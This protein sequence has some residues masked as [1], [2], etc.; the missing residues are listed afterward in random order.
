M[1]VTFLLFTGAITTVLVAFCVRLQ[2]S[3]SRFQVGKI[4]KLFGDLPSVSVCIPARNETHA[5]TQCLERVLASDYEKLEVVVYDDSSADDTSILIRSFA[6]V[7]VR[8][9]PGT[10]LPEG[11][12]GKNHAL[13]VL[14][15]EASGTYVIFLDVDTFIQPTTI[16]Q[17]VAY[18]VSERRKM[19]SVIPERNDT[20]RVSVLLGTLRY[21]WQLVLSNS[22][23]LA[24]SS[25]VWLIE[26]DTLLGVI[27]G[28]TPFKSE[29]QP[30]AR[31]A[32]LLGSS[33]YHC[34][35]SS[36]QLGV[37]YEKRW[38]SQI[39]TSRRLLYPMAGGTV[40]RG[41]AA[42]AV[43]L[44]LNVPLF[45]IL[46]ATIFGWTVVQIMALW[47]LFSF[48]ALYSVYTSHVWR[49]NWWIGGL[50]WPVVILQE[51]ILYLSSVWGYARHTITWKGRS[52]TA[53]VVNDDHLVINT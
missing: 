10:K 45:T 20:W 22:R 29:V 46:S 9:V 14:A 35:L 28:F 50:L 13:E 43:L 30:E 42:F 8:F 34:L 48:M 36:E 18:A 33:T 37:S 44:L 5:M 47:L 51:F 11:W 40:L 24:S 53:A 19:L 6:H 23:A 21:F 15:R 25:S 3:L 12:L 26:R 1:M 49:Q 39:E 52:V 2:R 7:G 41:V 17:M 4:D 31:I 27:G 32:T 16:S 38:R